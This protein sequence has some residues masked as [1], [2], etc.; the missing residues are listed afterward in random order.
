MAWNIDM[1]ML[2]L[3]WTAFLG[4]DIAYRSG[5]LVGVDLLTRN[6]PKKVQLIIEIVIFIVIMLSLVA[7]VYYGTRLAVIERIRR[8]QSIR[9]PYSLVTM[10]IVLASASMVVSSIIKIK[11]RVIRLLGRDTNSQPG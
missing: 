4:A 9:I 5:Q 8:Y 11:D 10:S 2:L 6:L 1:A 7:I 3:A